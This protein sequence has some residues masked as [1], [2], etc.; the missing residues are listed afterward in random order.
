MPYTRPEIRIFS[1]LNQFVPNLR[2]RSRVNNIEVDILLPDEKIAIEYDG[3]HW[4]QGKEKSDLKKNQ[5]LEALN[6]TV[7]R[8]RQNMTPI[9]PHDIVSAGDLTIDDCKSLMKVV[10][11]LVNDRALKKQ[12]ARYSKFKSWSNNALYKKIFSEMPAPIYQNSV[13]AKLSDRYASWDMAKNAPITAA[14]VSFAS[15]EKFWWKCPKGHSFETSPGTL[16]RSTYT[17]PYCTNRKIDEGNSLAA[18]HP[19]IAQEWDHK[20]NGKLKAS[21]VAPNYAKKVWWKCSSAGHSYDA[22]P[23][24]RVGLGSGCPFCAGLKVIS[25]SSVL[26]T[27]RKFFDRDIT[28]FSSPRSKGLKIKHGNKKDLESVLKNT[29]DGSHMKVEIVCKSCNAAINRELRNHISLFSKGSSNLDI[30]PKCR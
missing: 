22:T 16:G 9:G 15:N 27:H 17:C 4:H 25:S 1:E 10:R 11:S 26:V 12:L 2:L 28:V 6:Y 3:V 14:M 7:I 18:L 20:K 21:D 13:A 29:G 19:K 24:K 30:C 5:K 8:V 23:N